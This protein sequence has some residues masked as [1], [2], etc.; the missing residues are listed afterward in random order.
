MIINNFIFF[1]F[2][3]KTKTHLKG[4]FRT[5]LPTTHFMFSCDICA[6]TFASKTQLSAHSKTHAQVGQYTCQFCGKNFKQRTT[7]LVNIHLNSYLTLI[8]IYLK[9]KKKLFQVH[10]RIHT[11]EK[12][13]FCPAESCEYKSN[14]WGNLNKHTTKQH[15]IDL[16]SDRWKNPSTYMKINN[17]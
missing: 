14:C 11:G 7:W 9:T 15:D 16:R 10:E 8:W 4:H 17:S 12:R 3:F 5:H 6:K 1:F 13:Y 2:R